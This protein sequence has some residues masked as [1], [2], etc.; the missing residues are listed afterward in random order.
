MLDLVR[1]G[2]VDIKNLD[3]MQPNEPKRRIR[4]MK[5]KSRIP[6]SNVMRKMHAQGHRMKVP[7]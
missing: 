6:G 3:Y 5:V 2:K 1:G 7:S 4:R